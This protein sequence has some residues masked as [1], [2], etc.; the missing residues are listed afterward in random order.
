M[1]TADTQEKFIELRAQGWTLGHISTE[2][3]VS[4]R[5]LVS[6]NREFAKDI[7]DVRA[8][9]L[10]LLKE[11]VAASR[12]EELASLTSLQKDIAD[13]LAN[14]TLKFIETEKLFRL[15]VDLRRQ[16]QRLLQE[17]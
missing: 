10:G 13:E 15:S 17:K 2:L 3:C 5:T 16:I 8:M 4:K 9:E 14:R 7:K 6:W 11:R 1:H 12:E